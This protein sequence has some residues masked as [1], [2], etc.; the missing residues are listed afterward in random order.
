MNKDSVL[1]VAEGYSFKVPRK[2]LSDHSLYFSAALASGMSESATGRFVFPNLS[3]RQLSLVVQC[4]HSKFTLWPFEDPSGNYHPY[5]SFDP[6]PAYAPPSL[7]SKSE[8]E[9]LCTAQNELDALLAVIEAGDYLQITTLLR[10]CLSRLSSLLAN[11][12]LPMSVADHIRHD[13]RVFPLCLEGWVRVNQIENKSFSK[14]FQQYAS[15][16]PKL[17]LKPCVMKP[18][19]QAAVLELVISTL[20]SNLLCVSDE[21]VVLDLVLNWLTVLRKLSLDQPDTVDAMFDCLRPGLLSFEDRSQLYTCWSIHYPSARWQNELDYEAFICVARQIPYQG[22]FAGLRCILDQSKPRRFFEARA[23]SPVLVTVAPGFGKNTVEIRLFNLLTGD[24]RSF[25]I[26]PCHLIKLTSESVADGD[27]DG[28]IYLCHPSIDVNPQKSLIV[29]L[30]HNPYTCTVNGFIWCLATCQAEWLPPLV[31]PAMENRSVGLTMSGCFRSRRIGVATL[32]NGL[33]VYCAAPANSKIWLHLY[34]FDATLWQWHLRASES[35]FANPSTGIALFTPVDPLGLIAHDGW[36]YANVEFADR[37]DPREARIRRH[38]L[39]QTSHV[40]SHFFRFRFS[41]TAGL[42]VETLPSPPFLI[43]IYRVLALYDT[44]DGTLPTRSYLFAFGTCS[45]DQTATQFCFNTETQQWIEWTTTDTSASTTNEASPSDSQFRSLRPKLHVNLCPEILG[46]RG[47]VTITYLDVGS[48]KALDEVAFF[49]NSEDANPSEANE[50]VNPLPV[51][52]GLSSPANPTLVLIGRPDHHMCENK[53]GACGIWF[54][55]ACVGP[56]SESA[57]KF[58][59]R[60][61]AFPLPNSLAQTLYQFPSPAAVPVANWEN[62]VG[63]TNILNF[64]NPSPNISVPKNSTHEPPVTC[65]FPGVNYSWSDWAG[66][67]DSD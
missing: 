11:L 61:P 22:P 3:A 64:R 37:S 19:L 26:P 27:F 42:E 55:R 36:L 9:F 51:S 46:F 48:S 29:V 58:D 5:H 39:H 1:L 21:S 2:L 67:S 20:G 6:A 33:H 23:S 17:V 50:P 45:R 62:V 49:S 7:S 25:D 59:P 12:F 40:R 43:R 60:K 35:L 10:T 16:N 54:H 52:R 65:P 13:C 38:N 15:Q 57:E 31:L 32:P 24:L 56:I 18:E 47:L 8:S 34:R 53:S 63:S 30:Y 41:S 28:R 66:A 44:K 4:A 14:L